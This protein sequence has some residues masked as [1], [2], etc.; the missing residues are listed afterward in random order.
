MDNIPLPGDKP[1]E[2]QEIEMKLLNLTNNVLIS[3]QAVNE[4]IHAATVIDSDTLDSLITYL[5]Y[6]RDKRSKDE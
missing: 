5:N 3:Y 2:Q 6:I 1:A 4:I